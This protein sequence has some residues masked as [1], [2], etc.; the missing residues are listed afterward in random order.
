MITRYSDIFSNDSEIVQLDSEIFSDSSD[1]FCHNSEIFSY[2][3]EIF[4][5]DSDTLNSALNSALIQRY[6]AMILMTTAHFREI[7]L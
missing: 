3:S 4:C 1:V 7:Q 6:S 2:D 5:H